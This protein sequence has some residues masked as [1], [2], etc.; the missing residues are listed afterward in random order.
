[1]KYLNNYKI[2]ETLNSRGSKSLSEDEFD[3]ILKKNCKVWLEGVNNKLY[4]SQRYMG[5]YVYTDA[6]GTKR[7]SIE[8]INIHIDLM[9][10][11]ASLIR[12]FCKLQNVV[13]NCTK[14]V[15]KR[16]RS[17]KNIKKLCFGIKFVVYLV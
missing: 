2:Y 15:L 11:F 7:T 5:P 3:T 14:P 8:N 13:G 1:M 9:D 6:R 10:S 12:H 4:R 16:N 17:V